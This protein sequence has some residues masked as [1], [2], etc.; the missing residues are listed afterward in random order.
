M[1]G[2]SRSCEIASYALFQ[3]FE[4]DSTID[5]RELETI[6]KLA[7]E[8]AVVD[9]DEKRVLRKLFGQ[10]DITHHARQRRDDLG[11]FHAPERVDSAMNVGCHGLPLSR[12]PGPMASS[13]SI[14][15]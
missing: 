11:L 8:D 6:K 4:N 12:N 2:K 15:G 3:V 14:A 7:L 13:R 10:T 1:N 9:E 5:A